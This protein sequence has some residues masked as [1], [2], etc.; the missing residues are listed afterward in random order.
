M[1]QACSLH[2]RA[3]RPN[4]SAKRSGCRPQQDLP[5]RALLRAKF[6]WWPDLKMRECARVLPSQDG[7]PLRAEKLVQVS[8]AE[9]DAEQHGPDGRTASERQGRTP[10][11]GHTARFR[12]SARRGHGLQ[13]TDCPR[14]PGNPW[15]HQRWP[16][17]QGGE[18][19]R[20]SAGGRA[21]WSLATSWSMSALRAVVRAQ[22]NVVSGR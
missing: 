22:Q 16:G 14:C 3:Y 8:P 15:T 12:T 17:G 19:R 10:V 6:W 1:R 9:H 7:D 2:S 20:S 5:H 18:G 21:R 11:S 4:P 13:G